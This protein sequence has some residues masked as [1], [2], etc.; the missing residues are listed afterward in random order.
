[1]RNINIQYIRQTK[2]LHAQQGVGMIEV[3]ITLVILAIGLLGVASLQFVGSFSNKE[4][5]ARTQAVLVAEQMTERLRA[6]TVA[7]QSSDGFV[8]HNNYV[9]GDNYNFN[10]LSCT[11]STPAYECH[12]LSI[13]AD[14]PNCEDTQCTPGDIAIFDAY[15]MSCSVVQENAN[16]SL[17]VTCDDSNTADA[18][19]C[20]AGSI[21]TIMVKWP[22]VSWRDDFKKA[23]ANCNAEG[24]SAYD[25]V[26]KEVTL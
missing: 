2:P 24:S 25:C 12:C 21:H 11:G 23:N 5:L 9:D 15:E 1:M 26:V 17:F 7:S 18:D 20:T 19:A 4:A 22:V 8:I 16:A 13:P 14:I 10:N 3:L 6:S